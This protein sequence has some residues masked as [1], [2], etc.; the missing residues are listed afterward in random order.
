[1]PFLCTP[2]QFARRAELYHQLGALTG[3]GVP[4]LQALD[5]LRRYP[6]SPAFRT[7]LQGVSE[8]IQEGATFAEAVRLTG[9]WTSAFDLAVLEAGERS[10]RLEQCFKLLADYYAGRAA[11]ARTIISGLAYPVVL[12]H[13]AVFLLPFPGFF[14]TGDLLTYLARTLGVLV[15]LYVLVGLVVYAGQG[16]HGEAWRAAVER[17]LGGVPL[18]GSG[19]R[20]LALA[21]LAAALEALLSAGVDILEAWQMAARASGS[22]ALVRAVATWPRRLQA[23]QT[24]AEALQQSP[25]FPALFANQYA[26]GEVSGKLDEVLR[27]LHGYYSDAGT[28]KMHLVAQWLPRLVYVVIA[29]MIAWRIVGFWLGYFGQIQQVGEF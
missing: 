5:Q 25:E 17:G 16:Y 14:L 28:H 9:N 15:P 6:P 22:P 4:L 23:G 8:A 24:P 19:R 2:G 26:T 10:G 11:N 12:L 13:V 1:M 21:R 18:I 3:A 27:R 20:E 29:A 7:A